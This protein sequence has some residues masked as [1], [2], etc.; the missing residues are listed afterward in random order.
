ML[1]S[2]FEQLPIFFKNHSILSIAWVGLLITIIVLTFQ[3]LFSK[4]KDISRTQAISALNQ[5]DA[6]VVDLRAN[7][8]F[9]TGHIANA[10]NL[11]PAEIKKGSIGKLD[12]HRDKLVIL[13]CATG[14]TARASAN[15]LIKQHR[16]ERVATLKEGLAGWNGE[17]LPLV[18]GK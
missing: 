13:V 3:S 7:N 11:L 15:E 4:V 6:I 1:Q 10:I 16:F 8:D 14:M 9:R 12:K 5:D 18:K 2:F 17:N